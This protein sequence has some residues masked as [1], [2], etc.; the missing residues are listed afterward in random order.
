MGS[1]T[2]F[3]GAN[4]KQLKDN[5]EFFT[6]RT[7]DYVR[8]YT[9]STVDPTSVATAGNAGSILRDQSGNLYVKQDDGTTTNWREVHKDNEN[10]LAVNADWVAD[11][12]FSTGNNATFDNG[13]VLQGAYASSSVAADIINGIRSW[14]LT[15]NAGAGVSNNDFVVA[16]AQTIP[17]GYRGRQLSFR[18]QY[19]YD[20]ANGDINMVVKDDTNNAIIETV[21]LDSFDNTDNTAK[22][23]E[24]RYFCPSDCASI[25]VGF[26]VATH[27]TGSEEF[28][29]DDVILPLSSPILADLEDIQVIRLHTGNGHGSTNTVI[30]RFGTLVSNEG[31]EI[32]EYTDSTT[33]GGSL[34]AKEECEVEIHYG[35][36]FGGDGHFGISL[37]STQLTTSILSITQADR[38]MGGSHRNTLEDSISGSV[39]LQPGD[40][41]RAHTQ[42]SADSGTP[43]RVHLILKAKR[44]KKAVVLNTKS[45]APSSVQL[46]SNQ[47]IATATFT[48]ISL[49][50]I[51][52]DD[53]NNFDTT[54]NYYVA[55]R[56]GWF[57]V[58]AGAKFSGTGGSIRYFLLLLVDGATS[59]GNQQENDNTGNGR[60][61]DFNK[62]IYLNAG[63]T[64]ELQ[65]RQDSGANM[66]VE[67][68]LNTYMTVH[69]I[70]KDAIAVIPLGDT[71]FI[72]E[73]QASGVNGSGTTAAT[74]VTRVIN[75]LEGNTSLASLSANQI[76]LQPG[77][78]DVDISGNCYR[79]SFHRAKLRNITSGSDDILG[80]TEFSANVDQV[81]NVSRILG[82]ITI[83]AP[84]V[85]EVQHRASVTQANGFGLAAAFGDN[86]TYLTGSITK[87]K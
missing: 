56:S 50:N 86:E 83:T 23:V 82:R 67:G 9:N 68:G 16:A 84:T 85:F 34:T 53:E 77:T 36:Q 3:K 22:E 48:K 65:A 61:L 25:K 57:N 11:S 37:N 69:A 70:D 26:Q 30:R 58:S 2:I 44:K 39:I 63:Q 54:N 46:T 7:G 41:L 73:V 49:D 21:S 80:T 59:I 8:E 35:E 87:V 81:Q 31:P 5:L 42:G 10:I 66:N 15:L 6:E 1:P 19:K 60:N 28:I 38:I 27:A 14:K 47:S 40:V 78:Y 76:T 29:W 20:G 13:G 43:D 55:P 71:V 72:K 52:K 4:V 51:V 12:F 17:Q 32:V 74:Y 18:V 75:T 33:L 64:L 24:I 45:S 79:G 62:D